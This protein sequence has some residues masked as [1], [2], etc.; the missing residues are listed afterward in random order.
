[1]LQADEK[2]LCLGRAGISRVSPS[3][4]KITAMCIFHT[5][6]VNKKLCQYP[7]NPPLIK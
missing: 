6:C 2:L 1:M 4:G 7:A 3:P 5:L